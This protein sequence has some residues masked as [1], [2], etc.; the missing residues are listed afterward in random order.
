[1]EPLQVS[2]RYI[3][4]SIECWFE[5]WNNQTQKQKTTVGRPRHTYVRQSTNQANFC[6]PVYNQKTFEQISE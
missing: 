2:R 1:M 4:N 6:C 3:E 5:L